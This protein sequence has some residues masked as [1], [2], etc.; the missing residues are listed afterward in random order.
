[1]TT[2]SFAG[3]LVVLVAAFSRRYHHSGL[4]LAAAPAALAGSN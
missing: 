1:M 3:L 4:S 2:R